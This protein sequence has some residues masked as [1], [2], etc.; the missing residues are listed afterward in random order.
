[1]SDNEQA[2]TT[3]TWDDILNA[4][5]RRFWSLAP[6]IIREQSARDLAFTVTWQDLIAAVQDGIEDYGADDEFCGTCHQYPAVATQG[7]TQVCE[8]CY[9]DAVATAYADVHY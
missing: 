7:G 9:D 8:S 1:M 6:E 4:I 5:G 2:T 3:A